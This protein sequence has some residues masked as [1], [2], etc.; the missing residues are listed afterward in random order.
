V[1]AAAVTTGMV[2]IFGNPPSNAPPS[3][4]VWVAIEIEKEREKRRLA[5]EAAA[6]SSAASPSASQ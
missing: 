4:E 6:A 3:R 2:F 5:R 1:A